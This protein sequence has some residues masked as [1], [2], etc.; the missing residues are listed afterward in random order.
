MHLSEDLDKIE[1]YRRR[2]EVDMEEKAVWIDEEKRILSFH[3]FENSRMIMKEENI[4]WDFVFGLT[5]SG[6]RVM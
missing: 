4:F 1:T 5:K 2:E 3:P 6:Y